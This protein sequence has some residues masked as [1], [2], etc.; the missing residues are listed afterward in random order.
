MILLPL[1]FLF[2]QVRSANPV[3]ICRL[4]SRAKSWSGSGG[5]LGNQNPTMTLAPAKKS[6]PAD[7]A[8]IG[9]KR[10]LGGKITYSDSDD[11]VPIE[12]ET[13]TG[14]K[15]VLRTADGWFPISPSVASGQGMEF[16]VDFVN[17]VPPSGLDR[18]II[19]HAAAILSSQAAR[20]RAGTR[21]CQAT[22][23]QWSIYC[24]MEK[25]TI[26]VTGGFHH[27]QPALQPVRK[28]VEERSV[29][30]PYRHRLMDYNNHPTTR[31]ADIQSLLREALRRMEQ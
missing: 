11:V 8:R 10:R 14:G 26:G 28:I 4:A 25:A 20:N 17:Q 22:D 18:E 23:T 7:G 1:F 3:H 5:R 27:R 9:A 30:R 12:L 15:G 13:Y 19:R 6:R 2:I 24:A 16:D 29:N 21:Q 31:F